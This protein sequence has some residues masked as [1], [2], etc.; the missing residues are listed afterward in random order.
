M[1]SFAGVLMMV[2]IVMGVLGVIM[3]VTGN[4][5]ESLDGAFLMGSAVSGVL[6]SCVLMV[7]VDIRE[8][9]SPAKT[10]QNGE[11]TMTRP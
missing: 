2:S 11:L 10:A 6:F 3:A 4:A 1:K 9:V 8:A 5:S 7:L